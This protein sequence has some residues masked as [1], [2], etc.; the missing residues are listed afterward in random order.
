M[1]MGWRG[2]WRFRCLRIRFGLIGSRP[3]IWFSGS[4]CRFVER[5]ISSFRRRPESILPFVVSA[6]TPSSPRRRGPSDFAFR[7][8]AGAEHSSLL[9]FA[10]HPWR[11]SHFLCLHKES[12]Q[13]NAPSVTRR[14]R[15]GRFAAVGW[16]LAAGL[17]PCRQR[18]AVLARPA[19]GARGRF[20]PTFAA[21]QRV[22]K[23]KEEKNLPKPGLF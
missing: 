13:R 8:F 14:P 15:S 19:C 6:L 12:N 4:S 16:G 9:G 2:C 7:C 23:A 10:R 21:S 11:A 17:L 20:Q 5:L 1:R 3:R 18:R 22:P